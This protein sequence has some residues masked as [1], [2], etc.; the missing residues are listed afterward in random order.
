MTSDPPMSCTY[1]RIE[2]RKIKADIQPCSSTGS[3]P[4]SLH[5]RGKRQQ[6]S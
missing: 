6:T 1:T 3:N 2:K 4:F 5:T